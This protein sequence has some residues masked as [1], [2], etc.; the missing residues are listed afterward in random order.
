MEGRGLK[1]RPDVATT[2]VSTAA[3]Q[4]ATPR[5]TDLFFSTTCSGTLEPPGWMELSQGAPLPACNQQTSS[6]DPRPRAICRLRRRDARGETTA[7]DRRRR[8]GRLDSPRFRVRRGDHGGRHRY[9]H[10]LRH[11]L[12][13][14]R[15]GLGGRRPRDPAR[16]S[17]LRTTLSRPRRAS[18]RNWSQPGREQ[19][20][21]KAQ[22]GY[23]Y[24]PPSEPSAMASRNRRRAT[25][26]RRVSPSRPGY[27]H[28][29][30]RA[31]EPRSHALTG[32]GIV[33]GSAA[34]AWP[35]ITMIVVARKET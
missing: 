6:T 20:D 29:Y 27:G 4:G 3:L 18:S 12:R 26:P 22:T 8:A 28:G 17:P 31:N 9:R 15:L 19:L 10:R 7:G 1:S 11:R 32:F 14:G 24:S 2:E 21:C 23:E 5:A 30:A 34:S 13:L 33:A 35:S 16:P 25:L